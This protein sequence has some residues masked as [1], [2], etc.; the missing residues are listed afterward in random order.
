MCGTS[1]F[2]MG[3]TTR[4]RIETMESTSEW[5]IDN[6]AAQN[7][8]FLHRLRVLLVEVLTRAENR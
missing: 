2:E 3:L 6:N 7:D 5:K 4:S 8:A 1:F